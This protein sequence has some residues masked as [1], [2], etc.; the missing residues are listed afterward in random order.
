MKIFLQVSIV[1]AN[2]SI[3]EVKQ[4]FNSLRGIGFL[5]E[6]FEPFTYVQQQ[7][8]QQQKMPK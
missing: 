8:Q 2:I 1:I 4:N 3:F 7:K 6:E 5:E